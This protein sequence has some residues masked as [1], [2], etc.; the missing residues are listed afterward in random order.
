MRIT[1][2]NVNGLRAAIR[3][4][5][6]DVIDAVKP[7]VLLLQEIR[8]T[9]DQLPE[10]WRSPK[11]WH[12]AWHPAEKL[13]YAGTAVLS[14]IPIDNIT[15]GLATNRRDE[16]DPE[17][18]VITASIA[19]LELASVY[20]P[21]G[22]SGD[23]RQREKERWMARFRP[24]ADHHNKRDTPVVIAGDLN[25]ARTHADIYHAKSNEKN[26]GFLPHERQWI[27]DLIDSGW[28]DYI[29]S[30]WHDAELGPFTWWSNRGRARELDRGWRIDYHLGNAA[31]SQRVTH[32]A[33]DRELSLEVSDHAPVSIDLN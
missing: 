2:W 20:L 13:G 27:N 6:A 8:A 22:S 12:A 15:T 1:T 30:A 31:A 23:H 25:L 18:R 4:G 33:I 28:D 21:S 14:R 24:W 29:R 10:P 32:A 17:G 19:G 9:P 3:K 26:S 5:F 11:G 16:H 7:D